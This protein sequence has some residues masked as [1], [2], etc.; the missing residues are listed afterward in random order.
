V[1]ATDGELVTEYV[2]EN[3]TILNY[4]NFDPDIEVLTPSYDQEISGTFSLKW[5]ATDD[6][7]ADILKISIGYSQN[8][9]TY[10]TFVEELENN[11]EYLWDTT[12]ME[13]GEYTLKFTVT[14]G[15]GGEASEVSK[16]FF[17]K[18][19]DDPIGPSDPSGRTDTNDKESSST[20]LIIGIVVA[21]IMLLI[22]LAVVIFVFIRSSRS[23][24]GAFDPLKAPLPTANAPALQKGVET[25]ALPPPPGQGL[26]PPQP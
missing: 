2:V 24:D 18:N 7:E 23:D 9:A 25:G 22:I 8:L 16:R 17:I 20:G 26:P 14:D 10:T 11:G 6:N 1:T 4:V 3:I 12:T 13:D 21:I 15:A 19:N 5:T